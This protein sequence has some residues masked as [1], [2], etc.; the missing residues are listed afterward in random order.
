M[1]RVILHIAIMGI[2]GKSITSN[3]DKALKETPWWKGNSYQR[4]KIQKK[5]MEL[6]GSVV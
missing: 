5:S 2:E 6:K 4:G 3:V 1:P